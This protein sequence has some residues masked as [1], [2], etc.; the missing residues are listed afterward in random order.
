MPRRSLPPFPPGS[1]GGVRSRELRARSGSLLHSL[2]PPGDRAP[3]TGKLSTPLYRPPLGG[4]YGARSFRLR[5]VFSKVKVC[6]GSVGGQEEDSS[7]VNILCALCVCVCARGSEDA[8]YKYSS[9][10]G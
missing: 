10:G 8:R 6:L 9:Q 5:N 2:P 4:A 7:G 1:G 3:S